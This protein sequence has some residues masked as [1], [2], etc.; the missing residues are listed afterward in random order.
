MHNTNTMQY[1]IY[2][3]KQPVANESQQVEWSNKTNWKNSRCR[4]LAKLQKTYNSFSKENLM[5]LNAN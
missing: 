5:Q 4:I 3:K 1:N 2:I